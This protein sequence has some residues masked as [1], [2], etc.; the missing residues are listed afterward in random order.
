M[1]KNLIRQERT[2]CFAAITALTPACWALPLVILALL[3]AG[4]TVAEAQ[5]WSRPTSS[6]PIAISRNDRLI[7]VVNPGDDSVSVLR[8][9][10]NTRLAKISLGD[11]PQ[12][13]ALTPDG[14]YAYVANAGSGSVSTDYRVARVVSLAPQITGFK[15][16]GLTN[17]PAPD[18]AAY[19][20]QL[21]SIVLR[22]DQAYLQG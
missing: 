19:P 1:K 9:D 11:E 22:G 18:T 7:W 21:Q 17:P 12:S 3:Y 14:Q 6:N 4:E 13:V 8:P 10:N 15:F 5:V 20:N 16:P 2:P